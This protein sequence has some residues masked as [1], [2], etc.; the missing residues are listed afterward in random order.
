MSL[1]TRDAEKC[2]LFSRHGRQTEVIKENYIIDKKKI[3]PFK[4]LRLTG[5]TSDKVPTLVTV[6][7]TVFGFPVTFHVVG[8]EFPIE[9][10]GILGRDFL[11]QTKTK[12]N[13]E[14][15]CIEIGKNKAFFNRKEALKIKARTVTLGY[16][17][18]KNKL[19]EG[20]L[21]P[22]KLK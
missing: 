14:D 22:L 1:C 3:Y 8:K 21:P 13:F 10:D 20:Y 17:R 15:N 11:K 4:I 5:I 16:I 18:V 12:I 19:K 7:L 2:E 6:V 9:Q